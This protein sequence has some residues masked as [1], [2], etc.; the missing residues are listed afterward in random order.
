[1][2]ADARPG[3]G[4]RPGDR[5]VQPRR[6]HSTERQRLGGTEREHRRERPPPRAVPAATRPRRRN[7]C[8]DAP[9]TLNIWGGYPEMDAVYKKAGE[10]YKAL[11]PNVDF[12]V[13]S[14]DL[15]G[16]EQKLTTALP[17]NTAGDVVVRTTNFLARFIDQGLLAPIPDD[18]KSTVKARRRTRTRSSRTP[19]TRTRSCG[20]PIFIG[21]HR[22]LLQQGHVRRGRASRPRRRRWT[23]SWA[24]AKK[25]AKSSTPA[26]TSPAPA[27]AS[28]SAARAAASPRSSG[29]CCSSTGMSSSERD[30]RPA[31]G[32]PTTT[33]PRASSSSRSTS[34]PCRTRSTRRTSTTT[35]RRSR[36]R[37]TAMF[38]ARAVGRRGDRHQRARPRRPLRQ[39]S[40]CRSATSASDRDDVRPGVRPERRLLVG[41][42]Q[43]PHR[44]GA[45]ADH[46]ADR[47]LAAG[48]RRTST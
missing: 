15:R 28:G 12:T 37:P 26:A 8:G 42:H 39:R 33:A 10:A 35:R 27:S 1:M 11:H 31:S 24:D 43:V 46:P 23:S 38:A 4:R 7:A 2:A 36:P 44:A 41:L 5:R 22:A 32:P 40:R 13:F 47:R 9:V 16:F 21:R 6:Q 3:G 34:T 18:I 48:P 30:R 25:L 17:S 45:A 20:V 19:P 14:T 29:S